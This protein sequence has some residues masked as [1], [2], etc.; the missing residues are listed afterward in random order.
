M[1]NFGFFLE[2]EPCVWLILF[3]DHET[4]DIVILLQSD[5][6]YKKLCSCLTNVSQLQQ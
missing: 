3:E 6:M 5:V 2:Q 4:E 1:R